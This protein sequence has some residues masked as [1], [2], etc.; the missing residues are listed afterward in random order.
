MAKL[1]VI[2]LENLQHYDGKLR[3]WIKEW[4]NSKESNSFK[5]AALSEDGKSINFFTDPEPSEDSVPVETISID[6]LLKKLT[7][8][9]E[10][11]V[12]I[13]KADGTVQD[14]GVK[15]TDLATKKEVGDVSDIANANKT[16][17]ETLNGDET[18]EGSVKKQIKDAVDVVDGKIGTL[19]NL[20]TTAQT[21][22]VSAINEIKAVADAGG[23]GSVVTIDSSVTEKDMF[24]SYVFKQGE[25]II[26]TVN[27]PLDLVVSGGEITVNPDGQPA[28]TYLKLTIKNQEA[29]VYINVA[30]LVDAYTA[31]ASAAQ[32][33]LAISD[34]NE[35]SATVVAGSIGATELGANAVTTVKIADGNVTLAKLGTDVTPTLTQVETNKTDIADLKTKVGEGFTSDGVDAAIDNWFT[36]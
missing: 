31:Q 23:A 12:V 29:P 7:G 11:D 17:I 30:D 18:K 20:D 14:G 3:P 34:T 13:A 27:V 32:I 2:T 16:D 33:Q 1:Q 8:A 4:V 9:V 25:T 26:G 24:K 28:G 35:I 15:L 5:A 22:L 36:T 21:D 6:H 19:A 10:G